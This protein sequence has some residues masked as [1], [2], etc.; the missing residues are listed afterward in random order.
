MEPVT[1]II[2]LALVVGALALIFYPLWQQTRPE[3][4]FRVNSAGQTLEEHEARYRKLL[5]NIEAGVVFK[6]DKIIKWHCLN[7]GYIHEGPTAPDKCPACKHPQSYFEV[8][9]PNY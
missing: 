3:A 2:S 1:L 7:C 4:I 9:C 6:K 8:F 5:A